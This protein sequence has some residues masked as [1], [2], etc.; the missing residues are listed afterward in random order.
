MIITTKEHSRVG[1]SFVVRDVQCLLYTRLHVEILFLMDL[2]HHDHTQIVKYF[3]N[4]YELISW[5]NRQVE[6]VYELNQKINLKNTNKLDSPGDWGS[7]TSKPI[8]WEQT[9]ARNHEDELKLWNESS[10]Y[11]TDNDEEGNN[12]VNTTKTTPRDGAGTSPHRTNDGPNSNKAAYAKEERD[13]EN[14]IHPHS[15]CRGRQ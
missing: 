13:D 3:L 8:T 10:S 4:L 1:N 12:R 6:V 15:Y 11:V 9:K 5:Y 2:I 14:R 7:S